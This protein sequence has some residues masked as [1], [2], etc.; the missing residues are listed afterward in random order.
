[1]LRGKTAN[2]G[3]VVL[4]SY[5]MSQTWPLDSAIWKPMPFYQWQYFRELTRWIIVNIIRLLLKYD[6][7]NI[8]WNSSL[9]HINIPRLEE[10]S[11]FWTPTFSLVFLLLALSIQPLRVYKLEA[12]LSVSTHIK[13]FWGLSNGLPLCA[14]WKTQCCANLKKCFE[15]FCFATKLCGS[16]RFFSTMSVANSLHSISLKPFSAWVFTIDCRNT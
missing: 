5:L 1:M 7:T 10:Q 15:T 4:Y 9:L 12:L 11:L 16:L 13:V 2:A 3:P 6:R 8:F 14:V